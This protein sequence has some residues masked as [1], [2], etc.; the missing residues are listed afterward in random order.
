MLSHDRKHNKL[1]PS[2]NRKSKIVYRISPFPYLRRMILVTGGTGFLGAHLL[3]NLIAQGENVRAL[4]RTEESKNSVR[5]LFAY[6]SKTVTLSENAF[7]PCLPTGREAKS[8]FLKINW[9][10]ADILD[11]PALTEAFTDINKV[12]HCAAMVSFDP[13][14]LKKMRKIN[15]EGTANMANLSLS[16]GVRKFCYVSSISALGKTENL[17]PI[18]EEAHW[19]PSKDKSVYGITKFASEMEVWRGTQEG[20]DVVIVNPAIIIGEWAYDA[21]SGAL[22]SEVD[23]GMRYTVP[24]AGSFVDVEDV[25]KA[26]TMLMKS[27]FT[28]ERFILAGQNI[29]F[30]DFTSMVASELKVKPSSK[31][32]KPWQLKVAWRL[33]YLANLIFGKKRKLFR[34]TAEGAMGTVIYDSTKLKNALSFE[35]TPFE[36]T[37]A[38]IAKHYL[39]QKDQFS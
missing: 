25:V 3:Y 1:R 32:A 39:A 16:Q 20:L 22:F 26:M 23:S 19:T 36:K 5:D 14:D 38:R 27:D 8:L 28:N 24:G 15:V 10:Q 4:Y 12:Y 31:V 2:T 6:K 30:Q 34:A 21:G 18:T 37:I 13:K 11:I 33:D 29:R 17:K 7:A 9:H 35:F